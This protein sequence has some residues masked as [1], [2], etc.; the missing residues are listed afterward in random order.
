M[1]TSPSGKQSR[2]FQAGVWGRDGAGRSFRVPGWLDCA[3]LK[4]GFRDLTGHWYPAGGRSKELP[5][6]LWAHAG[7]LPLTFHWL[8]LSHVVVHLI[9][10]ETEKRSQALCRKEEEMSLMNTSLVFTTFSYVLSL[11]GE[12]KT[13]KFRFFTCELVKVWS[14]W[15]PKFIIYIMHKSTS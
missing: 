2:W 3:F 6:F 15:K 4:Y 11:S 1:F 5:G 8:E 10:R 13:P 7:S 9:S 12:I 14:I